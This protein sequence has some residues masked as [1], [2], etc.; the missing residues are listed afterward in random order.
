MASSP[1]KNDI[2]SMNGVLYRL[3]RDC[4]EWKNRAKK[5]G[6]RQPGGK[7]S[8]HRCQAGGRLELRFA[9]PL[10]GRSVE[11]N[12]VP[13]GLPDGGQLDA[14]WSVEAEVDA[15][16]PAAANQNSLG[17]FKGSSL[18]FILFAQGVMYVVSKIIQVLN[19][20]GISRHFQASSVRED[21]GMKETAG[22][23]EWAVWG[24]CQQK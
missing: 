8:A 18:Q 20:Q 10:A 13:L 4:Q 5:A 15:A 2:L 24:K 3:W 1:W 9:G 21:S 7:G 23:E 17:D 12:G 22:R 11:Q 14:A 16:G 6:R 19:L